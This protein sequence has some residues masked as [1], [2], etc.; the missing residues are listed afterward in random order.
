MLKSEEPSL[1]WICLHVY[2]AFSLVVAV[3]TCCAVTADGNI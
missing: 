1:F 3:G 2:M